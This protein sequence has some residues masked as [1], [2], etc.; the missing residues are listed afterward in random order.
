MD[1]ITLNGL[2]SFLDL[3]FLE[4]QVRVYIQQSTEAV[5]TSLCLFAYYAFLFTC[6][7]LVLTDF[8]LIK[9]CFSD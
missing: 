5:P 1:S 9:Q 3:F 8:F 7:P 2:C 6:S 4:I